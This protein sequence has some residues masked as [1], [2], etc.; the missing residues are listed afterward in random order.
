MH[1]STDKS[2]QV[3]LDTS[4]TLLW[5]ALGYAL[6]V[7]Y[8]SLLPF[9]PNGLSL[10]E[11]WLRF[12]DIPILKLGVGSRADLVANLI[13]YIPRGFSFH[14]GTGW[15]RVGCPSSQCWVQP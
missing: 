7:V 2:R 14:G 8:G 4:L 9:E 6:F 11:A 12:R 10:E 15:A 1:N 13:L 3:S 5:L